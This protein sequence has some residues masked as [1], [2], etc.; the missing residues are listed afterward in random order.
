M[1]LALG[2]IVVC[3]IAVAIVVDAST[4]FLRQRSLQSVADGAALAGAQAIDLEAYYADGA[5]D[6]IVLDPLAVEASVQRYVRR[7]APSDVRL[8]SVELRGRTVLVIMR[9]RVRPPFSGWLTPG[10]A[11]DVLVESGA[12]LVY[13][14]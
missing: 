13:R 1:I 6:R 8:E 3:L 11:H 12:E 4:L 9:T 2:F 7:A 5:S 14:R 10:G